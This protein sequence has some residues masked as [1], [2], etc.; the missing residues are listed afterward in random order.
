ML[1][2]CNFFT[3]KI[4]G[5]MKKYFSSYPFILLAEIYTFE[6]LKWVILFFANYKYKFLIYLHFLNF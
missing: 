1:F 5:C 4:I 3:K 6:D 2:F